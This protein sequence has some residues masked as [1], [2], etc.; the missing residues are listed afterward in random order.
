MDEGKTPRN[1][2][3]KEVDVDDEEDEGTAARTVEVQWRRGEIGQK[4]LW[5]LDEKL[6]RGI[7]SLQRD[8]HTQTQRERETNPSIHSNHHTFPLLLS[9]LGVDKRLHECVTKRGI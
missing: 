9:S 6:A 8:I 7:S 1:D 2:Q 5:R 3:G 4:A